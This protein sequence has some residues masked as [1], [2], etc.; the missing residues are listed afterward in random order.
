MSISNLV[1][2]IGKKIQILADNY[3]KSLSSNGIRPNRIIE[4]KIQELKASFVLLSKDARNIEK[5]SN[6]IQKH[7][8]KSDLKILKALLK[9]VKQD[10]LHMKSDIKTSQSEV[11]KMV[12]LVESNINKLMIKY[13]INKV[14]EEYL[15]E[16]KKRIQKTHEEVKSKRL[17]NGIVCDEP[18]Q[19]LSVTEIKE[20]AEEQLRAE[21]IKEIHEKVKKQRAM[22]LEQIQEEQR[23][24][25]ETQETTPNKSKTQG[26]FE[27]VKGLFTRKKSKEATNC[28]KD[29]R[30][31]PWYATIPVIGA[32]AVTAMYGVAAIE[33]Q[34]SNNS[35]D[36]SAGN[37]YSDGIEPN[38]THESSTIKYTTALDKSYNQHQSSTTQTTTIDENKTTGATTTQ[39]TTQTTQTTTKTTTTQDEDKEPI[40][41][42]IGDKVKVEDG[43]A[44]AA[45]CLGNGN[46]NEIGNVSWRPATDYY[47]DA[48]AFCYK[49]QVLGVMRENE[50][51][52]K[53]TLLNYA[54][55]YE[56][57]EEDI[58]TSVLL[59]LTPGAGDTGWA[60]ISIEDLEQN[61]SK[62]SNKENNRKTELHKD[63]KED[64][65]R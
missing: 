24:K 50:S 41:I 62:Q 22:Q 45:N 15:E 57:D 18:V 65:E 20:L 55:K 47:V 30:K 23:I 63:S 29:K 37:G 9:D 7:K 53:Q 44:Y 8:F 26:F 25:E 17:K 5:N 38:T 51:N 54:S 34:E 27:K 33:N 46:K 36:L 1:T 21:R 39:T 52:I 16:L 35:H 32:L 2:D 31:L 4:T 12:M 56:I 10:S 6:F 43:L 61:K 14:E 11:E 42:N 3:N 58:N 28:N 40:V 64:A 13:D 60:S 49:D 59:S 48:V 19:I